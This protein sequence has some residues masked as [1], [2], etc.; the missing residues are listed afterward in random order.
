M[1]TEHLLFSLKQVAEWYRLHPVS[2]HVIDCDQS[3]WSGEPIFLVEAFELHVTSRVTDQVVNIFSVLM[4][5]EDVC[6]VIFTVNNLC[7]FFY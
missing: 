7:Y 2:A 4:L 3:W 5:L 6:K 1:D